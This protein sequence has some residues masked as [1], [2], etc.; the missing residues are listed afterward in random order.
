MRRVLAIMFAALLIA[1]IPASAQDDKKVTVNIAGGPTFVVS[2]AKNHFGTGGNFDV[3]VTFNFT[4]LAGVQVEYSGNKLGSK[5]RIINIAPCDGC[6]ATEPTPFTAH[7][8]A[9]AFDFNLVLHPKWEGKRAQPYGLVGP[10]IYYRTANVTTP[11]VG[12]IPPYCDP[13]WYWCWPGGFVQVDQVIGS[14]SE[15]DFGIT[16]GGGVNVKLGDSNT[17]FYVE[18]RYHYVWGK[19]YDLPDGSTQSSTGQY[20]PLVFGFKF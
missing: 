9:H 20:L 2:S 11:G 10:G 13:W 17:Q 7:G 4:P 3:G 5:D 16:F 18:V 1:A 12:W 19:K 8:W 6:E 15:T 14:R